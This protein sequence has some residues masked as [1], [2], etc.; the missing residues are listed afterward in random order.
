MFSTLH[1]KEGVAGYTARCSAEDLFLLVS[2]KSALA[3]NNTPTTCVN[4]CVKE[5]HNVSMTQL[6]QIVT[7]MVNGWDA[8]DGAD[9]DTNG[10]WLGCG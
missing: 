9:R 10:E 6:V 7:R 3:I 2:S 1:W 4:N 5:A 8:V